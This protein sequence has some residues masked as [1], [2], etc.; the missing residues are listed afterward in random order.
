MQIARSLFSVARQNV[1]VTA[2]SR[3]AAWLFCI[4][5]A[6]EPPVRREKVRTTLSA[7]DP[8]LSDTLPYLLGLLGIEDAPDPLAQ[9]DPQVRRLRTLEAI[10]RIILRESL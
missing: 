4:R 2:S 3:I 1:G 7:L 6:D 10:R 8:A 9:M 5:D